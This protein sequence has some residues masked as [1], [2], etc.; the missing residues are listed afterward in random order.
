MDKKYTL[1]SLKQKLSNRI[2][3]DDIHE[4]CY[5]A[6]G[7]GGEKMRKMLYALMFDEDKRVS[8]NA[9]WIFTHFDL[10]TNEWLYQKHNELIDEVM[11]TKSGSKKRLLLTLLLRQPFHEE[12]VRTDFLDFC[13]QH[14]MDAAEPISV[15]SMC[16]KLAFEQCRF[17]PELLAE[18]R[19]ALEIM[20]PAMLTPGLKTARKNVMKAINQQLRQQQ[21]QN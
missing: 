14:M 17:F 6:Q 21:E 16:M 7:E 9:A 5:Y 10:H 18:L 3:E 4:A 20:E 11:S 1:K 19:N 15:K 2:H 8:E 13:M 12:T